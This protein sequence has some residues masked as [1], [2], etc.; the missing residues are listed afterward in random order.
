MARGESGKQNTTEANA[1][2]LTTPLNQSGAA[3]SPKGGWVGK[4]H[5]SDTE[6]KTSTRL[7][8]S[9]H[10]ESRESK[11]DAKVITTIPLIGFVT[12]ANS[13]T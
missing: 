8:R 12:T 10:R 1:E 13:Q 7:N 3:K 4:T 11:K 5:D 9:P 2:L 6:H